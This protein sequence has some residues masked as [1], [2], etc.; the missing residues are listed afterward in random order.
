[1][2]SIIITA[3][4]AVTAVGL[5]AKTTAASVRAGVCRVSSHDLYLDC[6]GYPLSVAVLRNDDGFADPIERMEPAALRALANLLL[7]FDRSHERGRPCHL[8]LGTA[9]PDRDGQLYKS[10]NDPLPAALV[11]LIA[12]KLGAPFVQIFPYGN[13]SAISALGAA[14]EILT[15]DPHSVC[16]VGA[17]DSLLDEDLL[18][19]LEEDDRL[20]SEAP[21]DE[22]GADEYGNSPHAFS[23][24]EAAAFIVVESAL[25]SVRSPR[26]PLA[27][28]VGAAFATEPYPYASPEPSQSE[29]L[30]IACREAMSMARLRGTDVDGVV[31]DL[32]GEH[33]RSLEWAHVEARCLGSRHPSRTLTH[34]AQNYGGIGAASGAVQIAMVAASRGWLDGHTLV[35]TSDDDGPRG[36]A[37]LHR[38]WGG[39]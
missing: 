23:P 35:L 18:E 19:R 24:G 25:M 12:P 30:T 6:D 34:P 20:K 4:E 37:I 13:A 29:G 38:Q 32:D 28:V 8:L 2:H 33:H 9:P 1:M 21:F 26:A 7:S 36:A 39:R 31:I 3:A 22:E 10:E 15:R 5:T 17:A 14:T 11:S 16:V 27:S